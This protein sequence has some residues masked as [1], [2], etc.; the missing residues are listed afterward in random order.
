MRSGELTGAST[1]CCALRPDNV[2]DV[3]RRAERM[4]HD[5]EAIRGASD[6]AQ[7]ISLLVFTLL[8]IYIALYLSTL[9]GMPAAP[10]PTSPARVRLTIDRHRHAEAR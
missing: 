5:D 10:V 3:M 9:D 7:F 8:V 2:A 4:A 1:L 6:E